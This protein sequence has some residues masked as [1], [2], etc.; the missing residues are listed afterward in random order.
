MKIKTTASIPILLTLSFIILYALTNVFKASAIGNTVYLCAVLLQV[1]AYIVPI[2][3]YFVFFKKKSLKYLSPSSFKV[4]HI[5]ILVSAAFLITGC[6]ALYMSIMHALE[7]GK[8]EYSLFPKENVILTVLVLVLLPAFLEELMFRGLVLREY[9]KY[10]LLPTVLFSSV[11][12]A[13]F[14]FS[15]AEFPYY[16]ISGIIISSVALITGSMIET[17]VLHLLHNLTML[18]AGEYLYNLLY[19]FADTEFIIV[20]LLIFTLLALFWFLSVLDAYYKKLSVTDRNINV[21]RSKISPSVFAEI[22]LS[23]YFLVLVIIFAAVA[24][25][26]V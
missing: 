7:I 22:F 24:F 21:K 15:F 14:H 20:L 10:G 1:F 13:M 16:F 5:K 3:A 11:C 25:D 17:F 8:A 18:F 6:G 12:F 9:E 2:V 26:V 4:S 23:P 19:N